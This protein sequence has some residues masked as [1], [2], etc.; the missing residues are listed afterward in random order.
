MHSLKTGPVVNRTITENIKVQIGSTILKS[1]LNIIT[2][3]A[4]IT[5]IDC[6]RSPTKCTKAAF[7]FKFCPYFS[8]PQ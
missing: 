8:C 7:I 5:P 4:I 2:I 3:D 6:K 1:G